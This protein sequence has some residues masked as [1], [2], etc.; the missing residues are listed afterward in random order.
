[1]V[2][3]FDSMGSDLPFS[4]QATP[5][6]LRSNRIL[7]L[8]EDRDGTLWIGT[9]NGGLTSYGQGRFRNYTTR[10]GL[11]DESIFDVEADRQGNLWISTNGGLLRLTGGHFTL[12][13]TLDG[14]PSNGSGDLHE[15]PDG[16]LWFRSA[17]FVIRFHEGRFERYGIK[18]LPKGW[19]FKVASMTVAGDGS[20]WLSTSYGLA[21][22]QDGNFILLTTNRNPDAPVIPG[23]F[24]VNTFKDRAGNLR[25]LTP[26]GLSH[27]QD[28]KVILDTPIP[29]WSRL[30]IERFA[31]QFSA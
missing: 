1:M 6:E 4:I 20:V 25:M 9:Q 15:A 7:A 8:A 16:S 14:L 17:D 3:W 10:D 28:G 11:P 12:Y 30:S 31:Y 13:T 29:E 19:T 2:D 23:M 18:G 24:I 5:P 22:L 21:H 26:S 27:Y